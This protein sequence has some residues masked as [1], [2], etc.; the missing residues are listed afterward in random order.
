MTSEERCRLGNQLDRIRW[1]RARAGWSLLLIPATAVAVALVWYL[2][3]SETSLLAV[4]ALG[5]MAAALGIDGES[6]CPRCGEKLFRRRVLNRFYGQADL[7]RTSCVSCGP[8][9]QA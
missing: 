6:R 5:V 2:T 4:V 3:G 7:F 9:W 1:R 8:T